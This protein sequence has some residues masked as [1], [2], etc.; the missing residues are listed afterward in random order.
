MRREL[1]RVLLQAQAKMKD[2]DRQI[3]DGGFD[4]VA[5]VSQLLRVAGRARGVE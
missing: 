3:K 4:L 5:T 2:E 1:Y